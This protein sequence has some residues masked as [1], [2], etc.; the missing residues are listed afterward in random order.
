MTVQLARR[1]YGSLRVSWASKPFTFDPER[2]ECRA[3]L[4]AGKAQLEEG[5]RYTKAKWPRLTDVI[6][7]GDGSRSYVYSDGTSFETPAPA[8]EA[9]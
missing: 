5:E 3:W 7:R 6:R 4:E 1:L 9:A 2:S 8:K